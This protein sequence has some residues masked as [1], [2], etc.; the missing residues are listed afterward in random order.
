MSS[1]GTDPEQACHELLLRL[2]GRLPDQTLWRFR[3]WLGEG[4]LP[5]LARTMPRALLKHDIDLEQHDHQLLVE[6]L[7]PHGADR[8]QVSSTLGI[9]EVEENRYSF[10]MTAPDRGN[11]VDTVG[12][13][14]NA[15]MRGRPEVGEVRETWRE[16][17]QAGRPAKR[18]LLV[19]AVAGMPRLTGELQ[20]LL[21]ALGDAEPSVEVL[22]PHIDLPVYHQAALEN[23][24]FV[25]AGA[26]PAG[27][28]L[29]P[30]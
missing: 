5:T 14:V 4:A 27:D 7:L 23:S 17:S 18:V 1:T 15:V 13:V 12:V 6:A 25:C 3:D 2:A 8:H 11:A 30:A 26:A 20:R 28:R 22:P 10:A 29:V 16:S 21:R 24:R 9:D 19:D